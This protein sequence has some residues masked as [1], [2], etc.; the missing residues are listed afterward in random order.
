V[1]AIDFTGRVILVTEPVTPEVI[2]AR[3]PELAGE[4]A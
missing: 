2:E 3:W 1:S 4:V